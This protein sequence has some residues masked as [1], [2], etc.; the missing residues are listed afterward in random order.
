M[1]EA[2]SVVHSGGTHYDH[3]FFSLLILYNDLLHDVSQ[4]ANAAGMRSR[5]S[6]RFALEYIPQ[7]TLE[8]SLHGNI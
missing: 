2:V 8:P 7:L 4:R 6:N 3:L 5:F 1:S